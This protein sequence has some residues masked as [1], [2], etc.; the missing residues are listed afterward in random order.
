MAVHDEAD[1]LTMYN[2][3]VTVNAAVNSPDNLKK[4]LAPTTP[5]VAT[6]MMAIPKK[7]NRG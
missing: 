4:L 6:G 5:V 7:R 3:G 2:L 1:R